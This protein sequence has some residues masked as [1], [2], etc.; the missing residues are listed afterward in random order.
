MTAL[1]KWLLMDKFILFLEL[2]EY[3]IILH[4]RYSK[5]ALDNRRTRVNQQGGINPTE[6]RSH[7]EMEELMASRSK[8]IDSIAFLSFLL[9]SIFMNIIYFYIYW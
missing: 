7:E 5:A 8:K 6:S 2:I 9:G 3:A 4:L 1:D